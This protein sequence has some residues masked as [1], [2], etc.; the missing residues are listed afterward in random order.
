MENRH[1]GIHA[2]KKRLGTAF[3]HLG[4]HE[5]W[6]AVEGWRRWRTSKTM[7]PVSDHL[8]QLRLLLG[9]SELGYDFCPASFRPFLL[10]DRIV[11]A[12]ESC[13]ATIP[14]GIRAI[15]ADLVEGFNQFRTQ[16]P[17][18]T[19]SYLPSMASITG[20]LGGIGHLLYQPKERLSSSLKAEATERFSPL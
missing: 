5:A 19:V 4:R 11:R 1:G 7:A 9:F 16:R 20:A 8:C 3:N 17:S 2:G 14:A 12:Q 18:G 10:R 15:A 6:G 13:L